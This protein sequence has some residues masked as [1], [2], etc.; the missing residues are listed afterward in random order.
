MSPKSITQPLSAPGSPET[1]SSTTNECPCSRA[2]LWPGGT[3]GSRCAASMVKVLKMSMGV[4]LRPAS[5]PR[6]SP[7][8]LALQ[9]LPLALHAPAVAGQVAVAAHHA[10]AGDRHR[11]VV[12]AARS[13]EH[14][15]ELQSLMRIS[16]AALCLKKQIQYS[17]FTS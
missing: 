17:P 6:C 12:G 14:T 1:C 10:M 11:Q 5:R 2:H 13:E 9:Q 4:I 16:Y 15:S 3:F 8:R 7:L